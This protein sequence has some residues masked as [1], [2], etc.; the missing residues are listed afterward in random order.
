MKKESIFKEKLLLSQEEIAMLIG[1]T[2][3]QWSLF[4]I[5]KRDIPGTA[6]VKL[7]ALIATSIA[8]N[9]SDKTELI[10]EK[11]QEA[12]KQKLI[13]LQLQAYKFKQIQLQRKLEKLESNYRKAENTLRFVLFFRKKEVLTNREATI[14]NAV[15]AKA[16]AM[17]E[18]NGVHLQV[19]YRLELDGIKTHLEAMESEM[20]G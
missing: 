3:S 9:S 1:I 17:L 15:E 14:L 4:E 10:H 6:K 5:G 11:K 12:Q 13:K 18:K 16:L 7:A 8:V 19:K 20:K 2:R